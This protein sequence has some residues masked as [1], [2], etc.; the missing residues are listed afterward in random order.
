[1]FVAYPLRIDGMPET[2]PP[3]DRAVTRRVWRVYTLARARGQVLPIR[4]VARRARCSVAMARRARYLLLACGHL[5]TNP[6]VCG[7]TA[8][9]VALGVLTRPPVRVPRAELPEHVHVLLAKLG[10]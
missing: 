5:G 3:R 10:R 7:A 4:A 9:R 2:Y 8:V 1:M 6:R